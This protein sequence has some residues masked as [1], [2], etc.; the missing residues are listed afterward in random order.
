MMVIVYNPSP[1]LYYADGVPVEPHNWTMIE[2]DRVSRLLESGKLNIVEVPEDISTL[3]GRLQQM[4]GSIREINKPKVAKKTRQTR[5]SKVAQ[6]AEQ[7][8]LD[9]DNASG[10]VE[11]A[12]NNESED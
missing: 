6:Q 7:N 11:V 4:I 8:L 10:T 5:K 9:T 3:D 2:A 12:K 1:V